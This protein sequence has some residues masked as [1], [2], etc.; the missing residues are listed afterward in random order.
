MIHT[1]M[2]VL[3]LWSCGQ[4]CSSI[5]IS[6][7]FMISLQVYNFL[8]SVVSVNC[9]YAFDMCSLISLS[10]FLGLGNDRQLAEWASEIHQFLEQ[11]GGVRYPSGR[12]NKLMRIPR[13][14]VTRFMAED[15][16]RVCSNIVNWCTEFINRS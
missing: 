3:V 5:I 16:A 15:A 14:V 1:V 10:T 11:C 6:K 8:P 7:N 13:E 4:Q 12:E 2:G 9:R